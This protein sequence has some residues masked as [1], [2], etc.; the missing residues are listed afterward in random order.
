[1]GVADSY[2]HVAAP[3]WEHPSCHIV[4]PGNILDDQDLVETLQKSKGMSSEIKDRV[5]QSEDAEQEL[6]TARKKYLPVATR[7]ALLYFILADLAH[8]DVMYQFSL[9][10][11]KDMFVTCI[12]GPQ[13]PEGGRRPTL[14]SHGPL[15]PSSGGRRRS[16]F[17]FPQVS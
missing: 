12:R 15:R 3:C 14:I 11:F 17:A 1:M 4:I 8:V 6:N 9:A 10:W 13:Q 16:S 5:E 2:H 7:G